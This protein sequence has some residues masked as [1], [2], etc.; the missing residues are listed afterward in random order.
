MTT[1]NGNGSSFHKWAI[2]ILGT[3]L[4]A[5]MTYFVGE[6][7]RR[8]GDHDDAITANSD[9]INVL[10][11]RVIRLESKLDVAN[12]KLDVLVRSRADRVATR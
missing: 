6:K 2:G 8:L 11:E 10:Y 7:D 12:E 5:M 3:I 9:R 4:L 1:P